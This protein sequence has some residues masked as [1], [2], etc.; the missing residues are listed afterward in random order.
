[1]NINQERRRYNA[2]IQKEV[3]QMMRQ[4]AQQKALQGPSLS[5]HINSV[6]A[7]IIQCVIIY[8]LRELD[9]HPCA[10]MQDWRFKFCYYYAMVI[11]VLNL[12]MILFNT[13]RIMSSFSLLFVIM[14]LVNIG[15]LASYLHHLASL[16]CKCENS[17]VQRYTRYGTYVLLV[18]YCIAVL[19]IIAMFYR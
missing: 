4:N 1:M 15:S 7:I 17:T 18:I 3:N 19:L 5:V 10:C 9:A 8:V 2:L 13:K 16:D 12:A 11:I 14:G 6:V